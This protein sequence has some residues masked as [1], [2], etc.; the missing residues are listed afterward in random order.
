MIWP[1]SSVQLVL[2]LVG[3]LGPCCS[4]GL[5][6]E[7]FAMEDGILLP[8]DYINTTG[9]IDLDYPVNIGGMEYITMEVSMQPQFIAT[10]VTK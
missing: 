4:T 8:L 2:L 5:D 7:L 9:M 6:T 10:V 1:I 3:L